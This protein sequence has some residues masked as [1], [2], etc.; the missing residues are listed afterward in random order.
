M[1][2]LTIRR[3][4]SFVASLIKMKVYIEDPVANE[5]TINKVPCRLLGTLKN[6]EEKTF[7]V[8]ES[9]AKIFVIADRLSKNYCNEFY[10]LPMG[11]DDIFLAGKNRYNPL[12]GN[13]F[14]FYDNTNEEALLHRKKNLR[15][16][17]LILGIA[18]A[19]GIVIG[20]VSALLPLLADSAEPKAFSDAGLTITLT[21]N[22]VKDKDEDFAACYSSDDVLVF[23][24]KEL[25]SLNATLKALS[26]EEYGEL[27]TENN[28]VSELS[29]LKVRNDL[30]YFQYVFEDSGDTYH[31]STFIYKGGDAFWTVTFVTFEE[32]AED[33]EEDI[34]EWAKS[35]ELSK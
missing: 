29:G 6:A 19:V 5:I 11:A 23:V 3:D 8:E 18:F 21:D 32:N 24:G 31:Y 13:A 22:F 10:Q 14:R 25:F 12:S 7:V 34:L 1:R 30:V 26:T 15:R 9:A 28:E 20:V 4:K 2:N 16:G 35:V 33:Y 17:A 27:V